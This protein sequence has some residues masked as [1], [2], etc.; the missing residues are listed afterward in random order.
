[1]LA[2]IILEQ[3]WQCSPEGAIRAACILDENYVRISPVTGDGAALKHTSNTGD[4]ELDKTR[5]EKTSS[6]N[7]SIDHTVMDYPTDE[8]GIQEITGQQRDEVNDTN[9][10][11]Y[12]GDHWEIVFN[13]HRCTKRDTKGIR[14]IEQLLRRK[15]TKVSVKDL[16]Y[17]V[18][19][20]NPVAANQEFNGITQSVLD[21]QGMSIGELGDGWE[22][23]TDE[24]K[25]QL[26]Q[27]ARELKEKI[28][29]ADEIRDMEQKVKNEEEK[30]QIEKQL[31]AYLDS[32]GK[33]R[34]A[35]STIDKIRKNV[36]K[37]IREDIEKIEAICSDLGTHL[38]EC[39]K[40]GYD[41]QYAPN[42]DVNWHFDTP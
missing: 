32:R 16:Y 1:M 40:T 23:I 7:A 21:E 22:A 29:D 10:I 8:R 34:L 18:N 27:R 25:R 14:Y 30:Y 31:S 13:G 33:P 41:C 36:S 17:I 11:V 37:R 2:V 9:W 3:I 19:P 5:K 4:Q 6:S 26:I 38:D 15:G 12:R 28:E 35:G 20:S 39:I 24:V 42:P